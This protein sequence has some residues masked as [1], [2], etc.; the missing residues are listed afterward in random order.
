MGVRG[1]VVEGRRL[2][3]ASRF[4]TL[5]QKGSDATLPLLDV[6]H[7]RSEL[8]DAE[9]PILV[10]VGAGDEV[11]A[12]PASQ[13]R[14][15]LF[16]AVG[17]KRL[18]TSWVLRLPSPSASFSAM[19]IFAS[20]TFSSTSSSRSRD[21]CV[22][23]ASSLVAASLSAPAASAPALCSLVSAR[24]PSAELPLR[25]PVAAAIASNPAP[26]ASATSI[27]RGSIR[28]SGIALAMAAAGE[29]SVGPR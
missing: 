29:R 26:A 22:S 17:N 16:A 1:L 4:G 20:S 5:G 21:S 12:L 19:S 3:S 24:S 9:N 6:A 10:H 7:E 15:R 13:A 27:A 11:L 8:A 25:E 14:G 2:L 18:S 28:E 23:P